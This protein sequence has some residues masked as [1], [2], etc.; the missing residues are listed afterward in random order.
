MQTL[1]EFLQGDVHSGNI[2]VDLGRAPLHLHL[3]VKPSSSLVVFHSA[4]VNRAIATIPPFFSGAALGKQMDAS[5]LCV[6][7]PSLSLSADLGLAWYAGANALPLQQILPEVA[8]KI[9]QVCNA[10]NIIFAGGS[11]GGFASMYMAAKVPGAR[12]FAV[13]PQ[14]AI[15][16][17]Y[18][19]YFERYARICF[20]WSDEPIETA[21]SPVEHDLIPVFQNSLETRGIY[22]Q[23]AT[24][25]HVKSHAIPFLSGIG[26]EPRS[27]DQSVRG[28]DYIE[29]HW[30][31]GHAVLPALAWKSILTGMIAHPDRSHHALVDEAVAALPQQGSTGGS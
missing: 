10:T 24:D 25:A 8:L 18:R 17:Y 19:A 1:K 11:G 31:E 7:D 28:I 15:L 16:R 3:G 20:D 2:T 13:N 4:A 23:N 29:R 21:I 27:G 12:F 30:G 22:L 14:T 6:S 5:Y 9:A 26:G